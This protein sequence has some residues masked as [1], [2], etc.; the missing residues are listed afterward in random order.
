MTCG[1]NKKTGG[2][3][4]ALPLQYFG[5]PAGESAGAGADLLG[6]VRN[7]VRPAIGGRRT[8]RNKRTLRKRSTRSKGGFYP[9]VMGNFVASAAKYIAPAAMFAAYKL[10]NRTSKSKGGRRTRH[11]R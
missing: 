11:R 8:K 2:A 3:A 4:T 7:Q 1:C 6:T 9:S 5:A 10:A